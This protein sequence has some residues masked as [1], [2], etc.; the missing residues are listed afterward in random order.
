MKCT[1]CKKIWFF[2]WVAKGAGAQL[3]EG[4]ELVTGLELTTRLGSGWG[5][6]TKA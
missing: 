5:L 1:S 2:F 3:A 4:T 6:S